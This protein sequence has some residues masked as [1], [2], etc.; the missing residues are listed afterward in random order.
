[1]GGD[2]KLKIC[3][4]RPNSLS[5]H[6]YVKKESTYGYVKKES[7]YKTFCLCPEECLKNVTRP[8]FALRLSARDVSSLLGLKKGMLNFY[9]AQ[10]RMLRWP[11]ASRR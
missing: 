11:G 10:K 8:I 6:R 4:A 1:M 5:F 2:A 9:F 7:T 3:F